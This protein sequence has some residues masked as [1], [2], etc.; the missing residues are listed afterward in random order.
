MRSVGSVLL[1]CLIASGCSL[2]SDVQTHKS[3]LGEY[4][5]ISGEFGFNPSIELHDGRIKE[6]L[7]SVVIGGEGKDIS[8]GSLLAVHFSIFEVSEDGD[9]DIMSSTHD[10]GVESFIEYEEFQ[11]QIPE[12][13]DIPS[14]AEGSRIALTHPGGDVGDHQQKSSLVVFDILKSYEF[15]ESISM[16]ADLGEPIEDVNLPEVVH[17][18]GAAPTIRIPAVD[19][20][21]ELTN[22]V[23]VPGSGREI[24]V[25]DQLVIQYSAVNWGDGAVFDSTWRDGE[26]PIDFVVGVEEVVPSWDESLVGL[27]AGSRLMIIS[28]PEFNFDG[29]GLDVAGVESDDT[30]IYLLDVLGVH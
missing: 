26:G 25:G 8:S 1:L 18:S 4:V 20:P 5:T 12:D 11:G 23:I 10:L 2:V 22:E 29:N 19:P 15:N 9:V 14:L 7:V 6:S 27:N 13:V 3:Q 17:E 16:G 30:I 21:N 28:P 24:E